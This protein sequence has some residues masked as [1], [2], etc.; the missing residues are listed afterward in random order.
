MLTSSHKQNSVASII[1]K[2]RACV[3]VS[4][5]VEARQG[6]QLASLRVAGDPGEGAVSVAECPV[7]SSSD[8]IL[9][10]HLHTTGSLCLVMQCEAIGSR[11]AIS[12]Q[13]L[14]GLRRIL[15]SHQ[16]D[17]ARLEAPAQ[18]VVPAL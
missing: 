6:L 13:S 3:V 4:P 18:M 15:T 2:A 16:E 14:S 9:I 7:V 5:G 10:T 12:G 8:D 17:L 1:D 11:G